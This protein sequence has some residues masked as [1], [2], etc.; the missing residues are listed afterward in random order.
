VN[1]IVFNTADRGHLIGFRAARSLP[2]P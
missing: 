1:R 2:T